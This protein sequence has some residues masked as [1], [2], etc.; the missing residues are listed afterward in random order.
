MCIRDSY[1]F[2]GEL[3]PNMSTD[4]RRPSFSGTLSAALEGDQVLVLVDRLNGCL[5]YTSTPPTCRCCATCQAANG[6]S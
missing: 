5:L 2:V 4:D 6:A 1:D 3:S